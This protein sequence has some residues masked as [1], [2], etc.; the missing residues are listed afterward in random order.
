VRVNLVQTGWCELKL[1][2]GVAL[3]VK[4]MRY[5]KGWLY[6]VIK[7]LGDI[8][9]Q[10]APALTFCI[11]KKSSSTDDTDAKWTHTLHRKEGTYVVSSDVANGLAY[12]RVQ[13][14]DTLLRAAQPGGCSTSPPPQRSPRY[15]WWSTSVQRASQTPP[16]TRRA[17]S[18]PWPSQPQPHPRSTFR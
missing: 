8:Q 2:Q 13:D 4:C 6:R 9:G 11:P 1:T 16:R 14:G 7:N 3:S 18:S 10:A 15:P 17:L 12:L 5:I